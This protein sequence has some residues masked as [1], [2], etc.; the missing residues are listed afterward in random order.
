ML[1]TPS[2]FPLS[3]GLMFI[4]LIPL[5]ALVHQYVS[6]SILPWAL[7]VLFLAKITPIGAQA[8]AASNTTCSRL[9]TSEDPSA[10][11]IRSSVAGDDAVRKA[12]DPST[13]QTRNA[14]W[15]HTFYTLNNHYFFNSSRQGLLNIS[16][17][18]NIPSRV[19]GSQ[20]CINAFNTILSSCVTSQNYLGGWTEKGAVNYTS[21]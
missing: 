9:R 19:P 1:F 3:V 2:T 16:M 13:Q 7:I 21:E 12:C 14:P 8:S 10:A 15:A 17:P 11:A 6:F 18:S 20:D 5:Y 4:L